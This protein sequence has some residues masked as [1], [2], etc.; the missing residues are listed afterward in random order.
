M[1]TR[2]DFIQQ[3]TLLGAGLA[4]QPFIIKAGANPAGL[5]SLEESRFDYSGFSKQDII[6]TPENPQEWDAFR[7]ALIAWKSEERKKINY[8]DTLYRDV[9]FKWASSAYN[10]YFLM[11]CDETF[12][13]WRT[14]QYT[15]D[16]FLTDAIRDFGRLDTIVLWQAY[17]LIGVDDRNQF[18]YYRDMPGGLERI[19]KISNFFHSKD[20][21][22][23]ICYNPWDTGTRRENVSDID[24]LVGV[25]RDIDADGIFLDTL[26]NAGSE[27]REKLDSIKPGVV[28]EGELALPVTSLASHHLSWAQ[29]FEDSHVPGIL[30]NK[31]F[32][33]RHIQHGIRR[34][35]TNHIQE[36]HTAWMNGSG[37]MIWENIFGQWNGWSKRDKSILRAISP[38][39]KR[40]SEL[41]TTGEWIPMADPNP[42]KNIYA[43]LWINEGTRLWTLVNRSD[44]NTEGQLLHIELKPDENYY[45]L[46]RGIKIN[47]RKGVIDGFILASGVG[48][49]LAVNKRLVNKDFT[50]F[51]KNQSEI[52]K[53][54]VN[55][56]SIIRRTSQ[57]KPFIRTEKQN[58]TPQGMVVIPAVKKKMLVNFK[59]REVGF[60]QSF[61]E[62]FVSP[63]WAK[64]P[65]I[66]TIEKEIDIIR[67]AIDE[68][69]VTNK[70]FE[71][72]LKATGYRPAVSSNFL[73]HWVN[74]N[75][76]DGKGDHP[77]VYVDL[78]DARAYARWAGKRLPTEEEWQFAA[79][80]NSENKYPWGDEPDKNK[81]NCGNDDTTPVYS[82]PEGKSPWGCYDM[83]GNAWELTESE[84]SDER[85]RFCILKGGSFYKA[86]GSFWYFDGGF[87]PI[88]FAAKQ[89]LMYPGLDR[90]STVGFRC[91][92]DLL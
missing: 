36:L 84:Y 75:I 81:C 15:L 64:L 85:N 39:Q 16:K 91:A 90:C 30:R 3:T 88:N 76:P 24:G 12:Y 29:S 1:V 28:L 17:P 21:K 62:S 13:D 2:R 4:F 56:P 25:I 65:P 72:F 71:I 37:V 41:F 82:Y 45:D 19:R 38:I 9:N 26:P 44:E 14:N 55:A 6:P 54:A 69:P 74:G 27:F 92:V 73:K 77:V 79:Q 68:T 8:Q 59:C 58:N 67:F 40:Y 34:W 83:C 52:Y 70:Q 32:E 11:M 46:I 43:N 35:N 80:G 78:N 87:L 63:T 20:I 31:W 60:Y 33:P 18:D 7:K 5:P 10:C 57:L 23:F 53:N 48:C 49:F 22:V 51:L 61:D 89:L 50:A 47:P 86:K 42:V 66:K